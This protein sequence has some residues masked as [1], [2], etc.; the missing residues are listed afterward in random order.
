MFIMFI[1]KCCCPVNCVILC[2]VNYVSSCTSVRDFPTLSFGHKTSPQVSIIFTFK[3]VSPALP[4]SSFPKTS[5]AHS[6]LVYS[7]IFD[8]VRFLILLHHTWCSQKPFLLPLLWLLYI[9][10][11]LAVQISSDGAR[12]QC[13]APP[14]SSVKSYFCTSVVELFPIQPSAK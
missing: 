6:F 8:A 11:V 12:K 9:V 3:A 5:C 2:K 1:P 7:I 10:Q 4:L 13:W 14:F